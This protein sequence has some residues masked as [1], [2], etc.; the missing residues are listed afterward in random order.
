MLTLLGLAACAGVLTIFVPARDVLWRIA[1]TLVLA[2]IAIGF[3]IPISWKLDK[4]QTRATGLAGLAAIVPAFVLY[5]IAMWIGLVSG[6]SLEWEFAATAFHY[7]F[8]A[9]VALVALAIGE[10]T[11]SPLFGMVL[12]IAVGAAFVAGLGGTWVQTAG[13]GGFEPQA[14]LWATAWLF[15][16]TGFAAAISVIGF[17]RVRA[18]W[19]WLGVLAAGIALLMGLWG[20]WNDLRDPPVWFIQSL[21]VAGTV[22]VCNVLNALEFKGVQRF[23]SLATMGMILICFALASY[24]NLTTAGFQTGRID[25][26]LPG[27]LLGASSIVSICGLLAVV[28]FVAA[29]RRAAS[30]HTGAIREIRA[31]RIVCPRC[32]TKLD[33]PVGNSRCGG[34]GLLFSLQISEP[35]CIK[36]EYNLLDLKADRCPECGTPVLESVPA[37]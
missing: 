13:L 31:V 28:I 18:P 12:L 26:D 3:A 14:K 2:G 21:L 10:K 30:V 7:T 5:L 17:P 9:A 4:E 16:W 29:N 33:A 11:A 8:C 34:C 1:G 23:V 35:R 19:R 25:E 20:I 15:F 24:I 22:G 37:S 32:A 36:C 27:R 6:F